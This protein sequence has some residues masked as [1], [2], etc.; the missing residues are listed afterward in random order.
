MRWPF[1]CVLCFS[2]RHSSEREGVWE[3]RVRVPIV[4]GVYLKVRQEP[5]GVGR[6]RKKGLWKRARRSVRRLYLYPDHQHYELELGNDGPS[7]P[8][9]EPTWLTVDNGPTL[10]PR[11]AL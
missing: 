11:R 6:R 7:L 3:V 2:I 4:A 1:L 8:L 10:G 9:F 5:R